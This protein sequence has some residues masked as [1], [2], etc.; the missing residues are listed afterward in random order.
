MDLRRPP[1]GSSQSWGSQ[2]GAARSAEK[3]QGEGVEYELGHAC[4]REPP[5]PGERQKLLRFLTQ[6]LAQRREALRRPLSDGR[7]GERAQGRVAAGRS[8]IPTDKRG[9][10][11]RRHKSGGARA[12]PR[13][14][15]R[16]R[17]PGRRWRAA[18]AAAS[19]AP[20][21]SAERGLLG[22]RASRTARRPV[23]SGPEP[24]PARPPAARRPLQP[25]VSLGWASSARPGAPHS[26]PRRPGAL[27]SRR[28]RAVH[29]PQLY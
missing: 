18:V 6:S 27:S 3:G 7:A 13:P 29:A 28:R 11:S 23:P 25:R 20:A 24:G 14:P 15:A 22:T 21:S 4:P 2:L 16:L 17:G 9:S 8:V 5:G 19:S 10:L 12:R 26:P 1:Q